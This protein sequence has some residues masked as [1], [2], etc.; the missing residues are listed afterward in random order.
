[1]TADKRRGRELLRLR[2]DRHFGLHRIGNETLLVGR[3]IHFLNLLRGGLLIAG[4]LQS[5]L[6][7][8]ARNGKPAFRIFFHVAD[9]IVNVLIE[10]ELFFRSYGKESQ[11]VA[12]RERCHECFLRIDQLWV[13]EIRRGSG[14]LHFVSAFKFP[15]VIAWIFLIFERRVATLPSKSH[16]MF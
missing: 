12:A 11:H 6:E 5:L 15:G 14:C 3:M 8:H 13:P 16:L 10:D 1:M 2:L 7:S 4:E 9:R